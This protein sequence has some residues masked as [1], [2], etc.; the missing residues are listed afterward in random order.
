MVI[1]NMIA[2]AMK[3][4]PI[5]VF[6]DGQQSRCFS[7]VSDVV[8][9]ALLLSEKRE[10]HGEVFNIGTDEEINVLDLAKRIRSMCGSRSE[11]E[12]VPYEQVYGRSFEDMRRRVPSLEK[13]RRYVG[14]RPEFSLDALLEVTIQD[15][16]RQ[17]GVPAPA[18][19]S[20]SA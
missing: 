11:I 20:S 6:G 8:R 9:G 18:G 14:Y 13:I 1:P 3:D 4:E 10:A 15:V 2:R 16:C 5:L 19:L 7:A 12:F 17:M